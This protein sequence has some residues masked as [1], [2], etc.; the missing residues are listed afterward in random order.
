MKKLLLSLSF[1]FA[2]G[3][4]S[5]SASNTTGKVVNQVPAKTEVAPKP[6]AKTH[7]KNCTHKSNKKTT[8]KVVA[9][10]K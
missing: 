10:A 8:K 7:D 2:L 3:L 5:V 9:P 6:A 4:L 1:V